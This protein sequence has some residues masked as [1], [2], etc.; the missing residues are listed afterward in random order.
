[1]NEANISTPASTADRTPLASTPSGAP[2]C[3][4]TPSI[5]RQCRS[6]GRLGDAWAV[7]PPSSGIDQVGV[8]R[9]RA[10]EADALAEHDL[11]DG[12]GPQLRRPLVPALLTGP[13]DRF[14]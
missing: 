14:D 8:E 11:D 4:S 13:V 7:D 10:P 2:G 5:R 3:A 9:D 6:R 12:L 1:M